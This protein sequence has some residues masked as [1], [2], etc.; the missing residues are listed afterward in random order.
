MNATRQLVWDLPTRIFHWA[1]TAG[2]TA[3][4]SIALLTHDRDSLFPYHAILGLIL[5]LLVVLRLVW[6][7]IGTRHARFGSFLFG[8][9]ALATYLR[10]IFTNTAARHPG[11]NPGSAYA[12]LAMLLLLGGITI[13]GVL[14]ST[15]TRG[16]K[17]AHEVMTYSL[18]GVVAAHVLGVI[19]HTIRHR[20]NITLGM[21][22]GKKVCEPAEAIAS[23]RP[24]FALLLVALVSLWSVGLFKSYDPATRKATI[25]LLGTSLKVGDAEKQGRNGEHRERKH[26]DD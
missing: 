19:A 6:G 8:P 12:I 18:L 2:L 14:M 24:A 1:L 9:V 11:H 3:S 21:I 20:E 26:H 22:D 16:L 25:P 13:T 15:G 5:A 4:A 10:G 23:V 7:F 17:D